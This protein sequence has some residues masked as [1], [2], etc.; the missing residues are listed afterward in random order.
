MKYAVLVYHE[1]AKMMALG[2]DE[3]KGLIQECAAW[4]DELERGSRHVFSAGLQ[5]A[6]TATTLRKRQGTISATDGPFAETREFFGGLTIVEARD[7][8]E[9]IQLAAKHPVLA[10]A[11]LEVRP[12]IDFNLDMAEPLDQKIARAGRKIP[13]EKLHA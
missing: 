6:A 2:D 1:E 4:I 3:L 9:A 5:A 13:Q 11:S 12:A 7:L 10:V 8:N